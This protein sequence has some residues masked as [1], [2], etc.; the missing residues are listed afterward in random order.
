MR[1]QTKIGPITCLHEKGHA[2]HEAE[3]GIL[4]VRIR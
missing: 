2:R 3:H 1:N 4:I